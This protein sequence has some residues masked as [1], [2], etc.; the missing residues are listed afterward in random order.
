MNKLLAQIL[1]HASATG[2]AGLEGL[3]AGQ[4]AQA[5]QVKPVRKR[6]KAGCTPCQ[7][8]KEAM[9]LVR[10]SGVP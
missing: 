8:K 6:G 3:G 4:P 5:P 7:A 10:R 9:R 1:Y 2:Q